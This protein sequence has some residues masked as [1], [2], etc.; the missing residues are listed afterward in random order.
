MAS[1]GYSPMKIEFTDSCYT[2]ALAT[3]SICSQNIDEFSLARARNCS[4]AWIVVKICTIAQN[5]VIRGFLV[6]KEDFEIEKTH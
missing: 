6:Q 2:T 1:G 5:F 4:H 3:D